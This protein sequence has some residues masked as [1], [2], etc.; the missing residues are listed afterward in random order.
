[1]NTLVF[2]RMTIF[3]RPAQLV[4]LLFAIGLGNV[5]AQGLFDADLFAPS[6]A[7]RSGE[8]QQI[9]G[10]AAVVNEG[11]VLNSELARAM[12]TVIREFRQS[13]KNPPP[14]DALQSQVLEKLILTEIQMQLAKETGVVMTE[15]A[16]NRAMTQIAAKNQLTL[17]QLR[18]VLESEGQSYAAFREDIKRQL[19]LRRL[20][21]RQVNNRINI[22]EE[23]LDQYLAKN[24]NQDDDSEYRIAHILIA[25]PDG[26]SPEQLDKANKLADSLAK[27]AKDGENFSELAAAYSNAP[28]ALE[29]GDLGWRK[30][31]RVPTVF[32][33]RVLRMGRGDVEGPFRSASGLHIM[34]L[35]DVR[36]KQQYIVTQTKA[37]HILVKTNEVVSDLDAKNKLERLRERAINGEDFATL[38]T[39][40]S[41][42]TT[43]AI[44]GGDLGW[45]NP[46][47]LVPEFEEVMDRTSP[48]EISEP[49]HSDF[50]WHIVQVLERRQE[51]KSD[52][53]RRN[54]AREAL[55][56]RR[57]EE[58]TEVW[59]RRIRNDAYVDI[60]AG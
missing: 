18:D 30:Y 40:N 56:K 29:G 42:D 53:V 58:E 10:I 36:N 34:K 24:Q 43:S 19:T 17:S 37:R 48:G 60:K 28:D 50:G 15:D 26:A 23:E 20:R 54:Q 33:S 38:A 57:V 4:A 21:Q 49:F 45:V 31:N 41:D 8:P 14:R 16:V 59:L 47:Q 55:I 7:G 9:E 13:G 46:G 35:S 12:N 52:T 39:G 11:I 32:T 5:Q 27:R 3:P 25:L 22:T 51:D 1:M 44:A 2:L 6:S